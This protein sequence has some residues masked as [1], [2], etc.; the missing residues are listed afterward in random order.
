MIFAR[1]EES[2]RNLYEMAAGDDA[3][4]QLEKQSEDNE[5]FKRL[6]EV[7]KAHPLPPFAVIAKYLAPSGGL[8]TSDETGFH[9]QAFTL[10]RK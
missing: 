7:L 1:P 8:V 10:K 4:R 2:L 6:N 3:K 9:Y 5:F